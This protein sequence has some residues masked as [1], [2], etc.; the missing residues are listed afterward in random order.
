VAGLTQLQMD[1]AQL[2][3]QVGR[4]RQLPARA[5]VIAVATALAESGLHNL[6]NSGVPASLNL[7][8]QGVGADHDSLGLYQQRP[9]M[10]WGAVA[11]LMDPAQTAGLFYAAL[12]RVP[13]WPELSIPAAA[14]AV[15]RSAS[16]SAY[17]TQEA[18]AQQVVASL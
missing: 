16:P 11:Q 18:R 4:A 9:S 5:Q 3:V 14:Q 6:A 7:P 13:G 8:H 1:N 15:Q 2:I 10:G 17:A 12:V